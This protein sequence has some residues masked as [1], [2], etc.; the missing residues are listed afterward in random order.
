MIIQQAEEKG[1]LQRDF[2]VAK[3]MLRKGS[4][5]SFIC[6]VLNVTPEFVE[7]VRKKMDG[8]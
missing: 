4:T 7:K 8:R 2:E 5:V 3:N 1:A 6:E